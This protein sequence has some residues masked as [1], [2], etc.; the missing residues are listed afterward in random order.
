MPGSGGRKN[1]APKRFQD[2]AVAAERRTS[3]SGGQK[4]KAEKTF[5]YQAV[6]AQKER[7]REK[8]SESG[9][10]ASK[11]LK[12]QGDK[13]MEKRKDSRI[14]RLLRKERLQDQGT[15]ELSTEKIPGSGGQCGKKNKTKQ[16]K[17]RKDFSISRRCVK[18]TP[19]S[20]GQKNGAYRKD[21]KIR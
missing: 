6:D 5:Q 4:N 19:G 18:R 3:V 7:N 17:Q 12:N 14:K 20:G 2:Q 16:I 8:I 10:D 9:R 1:G 15:K 21:S 11:G 13:I